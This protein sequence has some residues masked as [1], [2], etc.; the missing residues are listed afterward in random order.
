MYDLGRS[1]VRLQTTDI[2]L[3]CWFKQS[4]LEQWRRPL[5][6]AKEYETF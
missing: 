4:W 3:S 5:R 2:G 6:P 1:G